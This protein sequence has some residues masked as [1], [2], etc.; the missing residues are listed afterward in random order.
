[1]PNCFT[2][3]RKSNPIAGPVSFNL[4]DEEMCKHFGVKADAETYHAYWYEI[5]G[6]AISLGQTFER[7]REFARGKV[8]YY[9]DEM[10][11]AVDTKTRTDYTIDMF[12][13]LHLIAIADWL[14]ANFTTDAWAEIGK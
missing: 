4:I 5:F 1:M 6:F 14:E 8:A 11:K 7:K 3:T 12:Q 9:Q 10:S 2:L 13:Q